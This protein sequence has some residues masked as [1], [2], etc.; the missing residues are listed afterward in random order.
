[1]GHVTQCRRFDEGELATVMRVG[2]SVG[3]LHQGFDWVRAVYAVVE[4]GCGSRGGLGGR[5][6]WGRRGR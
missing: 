1:M 2:Q 4:G 3:D 6:R 5:R